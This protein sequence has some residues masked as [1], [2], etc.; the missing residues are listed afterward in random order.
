MSGQVFK[1][2]TLP[3]KFRIRNEIVKNLE[4]I[5]IPPG[6]IIKAQTLWIIDLCDGFLR[7]IEDTAKK[8]LP[9][10]DVEGEIQKTAER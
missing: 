3:E 6:D 1:Y 10:V 4:A 5:G 2:I 7:N 9:N 8:L